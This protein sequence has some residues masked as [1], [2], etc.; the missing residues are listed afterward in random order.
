MASVIEVTYITIPVYMLH[1][2][3]EVKGVGLSARTDFD[4]PE[5]SSTQ[6]QRASNTDD[7]G[8]AQNGPLFERK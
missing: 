6:T 4:V 7:H 8:Q 2:S 3:Q 1:V 5:S